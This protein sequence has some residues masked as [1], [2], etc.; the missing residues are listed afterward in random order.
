M[1]TEGIEPW[2]AR[3]KLLLGEE[4]LSKIINSHVLVVG[5]GGVGGIAAEMIC[6]AGVKKMTLVDADIVE[7]TNKNRQLPALSS[8]N[9]MYKAEVLAKRFTDINPSIELKI[10]TEYITKENTD[11]LLDAEKYDYIV[12]AIDTL[13]PKVNLILKSRERRIPLVSSMG[14]GGRLDPSRI[15]IDDIKNS[16]NC[17]LAKEV[18]KK[19]KKYRIY[20]GIKVV[21]SPELPD[22]NRLIHTPDDMKKKSVIGTISYMPAMF[23]CTLASVVIRDLAEKRLKN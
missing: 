19:L 17:H 12:D 18:R 2:M 22:K 21:Y 9:G 23:G 16:R 11:A 8:T 14:A 15:K 7:P 5:L 6:R 13:G 4:K 1:G 3:T 20:S 10:I